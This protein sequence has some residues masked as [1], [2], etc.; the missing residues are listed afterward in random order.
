MSKMPASLI[1]FSEIVFVIAT[2]MF[3]GLG[4]AEETELTDGLRLVLPKDV[5]VVPWPQVRDQMPNAQPGK[6]YMV[7]SD[8]SFLIMK[9]KSSPVV[10]K[11]RDLVKLAD[12]AHAAVSARQKGMKF[13]A[14]EIIDLSGVKFARVHGVGVVQE[15]VPCGLTFLIV[16]V[17]DGSAITLMISL[18]GETGVK[19]VEEVEKLTKSIRF[20]R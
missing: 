12:S 18:K 6:T 1:T 5:A 10:E 8:N 7:N 3:L 9:S 2:A 15:M 4:H 20:I 19:R 11:D 13:E 17:S 16:L 14:V